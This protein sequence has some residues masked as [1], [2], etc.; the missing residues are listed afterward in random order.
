[1]F[2][3]VYYGLIGILNICITVNS[4]TFDYSTLDK[5]NSNT[6]KDCSQIHNTL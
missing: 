4:T 6:N 1:V 5:N 3:N 2:G